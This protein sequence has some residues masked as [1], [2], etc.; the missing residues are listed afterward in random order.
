LIGQKPVDWD[1]LKNVDEL[2]R[3]IEFQHMN[4][5]ALTES[6]LN[7]LKVYELDDDNVPDSSSD[8]SS[9]SSGSDCY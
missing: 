5:R 9:S 7:G 1:F 4:L 8:E 2:A 3:V 6:D